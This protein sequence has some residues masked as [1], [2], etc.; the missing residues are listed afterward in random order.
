MQKMI[1]ILWVFLFVMNFGVNSLLA[2]DNPKLLYSFSKKFNFIEILDEASLIVRVKTSLNHCEELQK[3]YLQS[4]IKSK[5]AIQVML[6]DEY[7]NIGLG[8]SNLGLYDLSAFYY[9]KAFEL[10]TKDVGKKYDFAIEKVNEGNRDEGMAMLKEVLVEC[11]EKSF[12][13]LNYGRVFYEDEDFETAI[14]EA[15][16]LIQQFPN[17]QEANYAMIIKILA[18]SQL[19]KKNVRINQDQVS[20]LDLNVWPGQFIQYHLGQMSVKQFVSFLQKQDEG[21]FR[22]MMT[23]TSYYLGEWY[24]ANKKHSEAK[25]FFQKCLDFRVEGYVENNSSKKRIREMAFFNKK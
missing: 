25:Q 13:R 17:S 20:K 16:T 1:R 24:L 10:D 4:D 18:Q 22:R 19:G 15:D 3:I 2:F 6:S 7:G 21:T 14:V 12:Y 5:P 11:P 23:E 8:F 9:K